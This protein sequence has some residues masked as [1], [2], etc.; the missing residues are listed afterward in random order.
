[1]PAIIIGSQSYNIVESLDSVTIADS[2]ALIKLQT[3]RGHGEAKLYVGPQN[4][5]TRNFFSNINAE[6]FFL[7]ED[8]INYL[9]EAELEYENPQQD[10]RKATSQLRIEWARYNSQ[11]GTL[12]TDKRIF[13]ITVFQDRQ[14]RYYIRSSDNIFRFMRGIAL[15]QISYLTILKLRDL[16]GTISYYFRLFLDTDYN[17]MNNRLA[18]EHAELEISRDVS[19][20]VTERKQLIKARIG[21]GVFRDGL[22]QDFNQCPITGVTDKRILIASHIKPWFVSDNSEKLDHKNGLLLTPTYDRLFDRGLISFE[23]DGT[24][25]IS[26]YLSNSNRVKLN[27]APNTQYNIL[28][29]GREAYLQYHRTHI[30]RA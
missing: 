16:A 13:S 9:S 1:M 27:L 11:A 28:P 3:T 20:T 25:L 23:N 17:T 15:P 8:L 10:Y 12:R 30:F 7:K 14:N 4:T 2:F 5:H 21:Q 26:P 6:C 22:L 29:L 24:I 19:I 18:V